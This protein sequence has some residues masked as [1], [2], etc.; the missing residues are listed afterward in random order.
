[1]FVL[2][3]VLLLL[4]YAGFLVY[5]VAF[6]NR[7][8]LNLKTWNPLAY[9][10]S[11]KA[12]KTLAIDDPIA[13]TVVGLKCRFPGSDITNNKVF[14]KEGEPL[15]LNT[16]VACTSCNQYVFKS[17]GK[18]SLYH[19]DKEFNERGNFQPAVGTCTSRKKTGA[20]PF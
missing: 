4:V 9:E 19:Y 11:V 12:V 3:L 1:M 20:C 16:E 5:Q 18:C 17:G 8:L 2:I 13:P 6:E 15:D 14:D 10:K 7:S